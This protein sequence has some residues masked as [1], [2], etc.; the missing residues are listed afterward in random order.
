MKNRWGIFCTITGG[1]TGHRVA[2]LH[3]RGQLCLYD[4]QQQAEAKAKQ[5][6]DDV[7]IVFNAMPRA[8]RPVAT[9]EARPY[10]EDAI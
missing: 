5:V 1:I 7:Q 3:D 6:S 8:R 2:W 9:Y 10:T 4:D